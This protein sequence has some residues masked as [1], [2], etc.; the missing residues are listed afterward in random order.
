[1]KYRRLAIIVIACLSFADPSLAQAKSFEILNQ[2]VEQ[3][4]TVIIRIFPQ[5]QGSMVCVLAFDKQY[6]PNKYGYVFIGIDVNTEPTGTQERPNKYQAYLVECGRGVRLDWYYDE[7]E[8]LKK[9][10]GTPWYAG[11]VKMPSK[12]VQERRAK[13]V[14]II[15]A[16]Y[17]LANKYEDHTFG[18]FIP[19][20]NSI[21]VTDTFGTPRLYG[22]YDRKNKRIRV[23]KEVPHGGVD[24]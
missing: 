23:E 18:D 5:W 11:P 19:P 13:D 12:D 22:S 3:G 10:F 15:H 21:D 8:V 20:L 1:M 2:R 16:A 9:D 7:I 6:V 24:F 14:A 17:N 4:D